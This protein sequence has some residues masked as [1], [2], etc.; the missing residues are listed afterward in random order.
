[1]SV[2]AF[3]ENILPEHL[4]D[5]IKAYITSRR[6]VYTPVRQEYVG[7][8]Y[9]SV[10]IFRPQNGHPMEEHVIKSMLYF[11]NEYFNYDLCGTFEVQVLKYHANDGFKWHC[12]YGVSENPEAERKL[13]MTLQLS[14]ERDYEGGELDI[15]D[16]Y[17]REHSLSKQYGSFIVFDSRVP[18]RV[19]PVTKGLRYSVV[20]W[21]HGP[22]LR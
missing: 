18:H 3:Y 1:M 9:R 19:R 2:E 17:N 8:L 13:S 6:A 7:D 21:A 14:G 15:I 5:P 22:Q 20:A 11:N 10:E 12:D 16:W 4:V